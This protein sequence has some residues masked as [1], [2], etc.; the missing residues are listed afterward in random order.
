MFPRPSF[1]SHLRGTLAAA[2]YCFGGVPEYILRLFDFLHTFAPAEL[3][4][5]NFV[6]SHKSSAN[7]NIWTC[8]SRFNFFFLFIVSNALMTCVDLLVAASRIGK[9]NHFLPQEGEG[10]QEKSGGGL[11]ISSLRRRWSR[12]R[13]EVQ[14]NNKMSRLLTYPV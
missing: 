8:V 6:H 14:F 9:L 5:V 7:L 10:G 11:L 4:T 1:S 12:L 13:P 2:C 3:Q